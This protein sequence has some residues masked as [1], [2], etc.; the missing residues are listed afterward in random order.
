M[1]LAVRLYRQKETGAGVLKMIMLRMMAMRL[2]MMP[3]RL[4]MMA[5]RLRNPQ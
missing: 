4:R 5:M 2:R 3:M 1:D